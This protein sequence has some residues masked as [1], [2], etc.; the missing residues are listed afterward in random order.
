MA[1]YLPVLDELRNL[2]AEIISI[3]NDLVSAEK[4]EAQGDTDNNLLLILEKQEGYSRP[5]AIEKLRQMTHERFARFLRLE[6]QIPDMDSMLEPAERV[7]MRR[8]IQGLHDL[9]A[10]DNE[11]E[12]TSGRYAVD[13]TKPKAAEEKSFAALG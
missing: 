12:H 10:G 2:A 11:W 4:E 9:V 7:A 6:Q 8:Y 3:T 13:D 1:F 5:A